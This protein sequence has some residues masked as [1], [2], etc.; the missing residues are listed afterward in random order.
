MDV[1][2]ALRQLEQERTESFDFIFM[3]PPYQKQ[4]ERRAL[5]YLKDSG[6]VSEDTVLIIEAAKET[7]F[8]YL[9]DL[10]YEIQK[11]KNYKTNVHVFLK[12][13]A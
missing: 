12:R 11:I 4:F 13:S 3:D 8:S 7:D 10:G 9:D 6:L 2:A 1:F 5:E